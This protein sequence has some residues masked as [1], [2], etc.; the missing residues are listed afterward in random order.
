MLCVL[1]N[2]ICFER[3]ARSRYVVVVVM[4]RKAAK[5]S[6]MRARQYKQSGSDSAT[7]RKT[8]ELD[9][10]PRISDISMAK[11]PSQDTMVKHLSA[12]RCVG[13]AM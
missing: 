12:R 11:M 7:Q 9:G 6:A 5:L 2:G 13:Q 8:T 1:L 3:G 4:E 10:T